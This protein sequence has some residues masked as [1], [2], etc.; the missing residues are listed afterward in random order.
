VEEEEEVED[1]DCIS[2]QSKLHRKIY[3]YP[4]PGTAEYEGSTILSDA[5]RAARAAKAAT[6]ASASE[7]HGPWIRYDRWAR[8][9]RAGPVP[10]DVDS[11]VVP[12][13]TELLLVR[14]VVAHPPQLLAHVRSRSSALLLFTS[15]TCPASGRLRP[16]GRNYTVQSPYGQ[17]LLDAMAHSQLLREMGVAPLLRVH[18]D[19]LGAQERV[20]SLVVVYSEPLHGSYHPLPAR[21]PSSSWPP[22]IGR[23]SME[24]SRTFVKV[25]PRCARKNVL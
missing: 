10:C 15:R 17:A 2:R 7:P 25:H 23:Q 14:G 22:P 1:R 24:R 5:A 8:L 3:V 9:N 12:C 6:A 11:K 21:T 4:D 19:V 13:S 16:A 20:R 18:V